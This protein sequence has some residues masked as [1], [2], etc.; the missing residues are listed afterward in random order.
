MLETMTRCRWNHRIG[1]ALQ[2]WTVSYG[3]GNWLFESPDG[4][5]QFQ[6][7][8]DPGTQ[9]KGFPPTIHSFDSIAI[10]EMNKQV[11]AV[12]TLQ[13]ANS[14]Q[15]GLLW[16]E[17]F[18]SST[19]DNARGRGRVSFVERN[20]WGL[21]IQRKAMQIISL[22]RSGIVIAFE[23]SLTCLD[24]WSGV[25]LWTIRGVKDCS[26][27]SHQESIYLYQ[28]QSQSIAQLDIRD[29][30][31]QTDVKVEIQPGK[32]IASIGKYILFSSSSGKQNSLRL[33]NA[34]NGKVVF[35]KLFASDTRL[36]F[37]D[38]SSLVAL[39]G[40]R[41]S[42]DGSGELT[43]WNL[44]NETESIS[45]VQVEGTF[46]WINVQRF[47]DTLLIL[48]FAISQS[49]DSIAVWPDPSDPLFVPVAG[50]M[51]AISAKDGRALWKQNNFAKMFFL[52]VA[53]DRSSP[54]AFFVRRL[55]LSKI[56]DVNPD[57]LSVAIVDV[58]DGQVLYA[59]DDLPAIRNLGFSQQI[60]PTKNAISITFLGTSVDVVWSNKDTE[61][62]E[63]AA[64]ENARFD[65]GDIDYRPFRKEIEDRILKMRAADL[66]KANDQDMPPDP[67]KE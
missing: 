60:D 49:L 4:K 54:L 48:P 63:V 41:E 50:R 58:R 26:F 29:G 17:A 64:T 36:A 65:F 66:E 12:N 44:L 32:S 38:E 15:D 2:D 56:A 20:S 24:L 23:D 13:A 53:Q 1:N 5:G 42:A 14:E 52:P 16:R 25:K 62:P 43:F 39:S 45:K 31:K 55:T 19:P 59:K 30:M 18:E 7:Y 46:G 9:E 11:F 47:A 67:D 57:L 51:I 35:E 21:P 34:T 33:L 6:I 40:A 22:S 3:P 10:V 27:A 61:N 28:P 37:D 8:V